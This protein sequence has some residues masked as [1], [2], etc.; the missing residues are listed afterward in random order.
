MKLRSDQTLK[1]EDINMLS[2]RQLYEHF[3]YV[4][5]KMNKFEEYDLYAENKDFL[6]G[7]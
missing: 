4:H 7:D 2:L 1:K 6:A 3:G 5:Y